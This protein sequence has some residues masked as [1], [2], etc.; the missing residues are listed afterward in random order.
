MTRVCGRRL[1]YQFG[2]NA[3]GWQLDYSQTVQ[4]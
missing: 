4:S 3:D 1:V 2:P